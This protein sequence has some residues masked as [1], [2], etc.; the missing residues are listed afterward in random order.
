[1][2][3]N[4][5]FIGKLVSHNQTSASGVFDTFD[6][7]NYRR[8][9][10]WPLSFRYVS[11]SPGSGSILENSTTSFTFTT[12]GFESNTTLYWT[13]LNGTTTS[14]DFFSSVVS[15]NFTQSGST[16]TGSFSVS[17]NLIANTAKAARTFQIQI[18]TG[19]TSGPVVFTSGTFSIPAITANV[20]T[21]LSSIN[22]GGSFIVSTVIGNMNSSNSFTASFSY[23]G[24]ATSADFSGGLPSSFTVT[25]ATTY[26]T[27]FTALADVT[28][29]GNETIN[30]VVSLQGNTL[31]STGSITINDTS[32][33]AT[34][35]VG[36][37][38]NPINE[39]TTMTVTVTTTNVSNGTTLY[40]TTE[41]V[42]NWEGSDLSATSG[43]FTVN[44]NS[45]SFT[46]NTTADGYTEGTEQFLIRI[47]LNSTSGTIIGSSATI[48]ISDTSTGTPEPTFNQ[49]LF[50]NLCAY[51]DDYMSE[52]RNPSFYSYALNGDQT[53][54]SDGGGDMYDTGNFTYAWVLSNTIYAGNHFS[55]VAPAVTIGYSNSSASV[56]IDTSFV[57]RSLGYSSGQ[58]PLTVL[59]Y[60]TASNTPIGFQK[61]GN[62]GADGGG[63]QANGL[64]YD[65]ATVNTF[66]V[67][68]FRRITFNAGDPSVCDLYML[69]GHPNWGSSFGARTFSGDASTDSGGSYFYAASST[70]VVAVAML[71]SKSGGVEVTA[72]ECQTVIQNFTSRMKIHLG[73]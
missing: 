70:N 65:N 9:S 35:S 39:G 54:I 45:G 58:L 5:N 42:S 34:A 49:T 29:E 50:D 61:G 36:L 19:S 30:V 55:S 51:L 6:A 23:S 13:I 41:N 25:N 20:S 16:N 52:Y 60:R 47:R 15:G 44:S 11:L 68:A 1:M 40:W 56:T 62:I 32:Q 43:S 64:V 4:G 10:L 46:F 69:I 33:T 66:T 21:N 72:A 12:A 17:T 37:S 27:T 22:E 31:G 2:R 57:Y 24:T 8:K 59:A 71:L 38:A 53:F 73:Y 14:S 63:S 18:R 26:T 7:Y 3:R 48:S 28:T 67:Y